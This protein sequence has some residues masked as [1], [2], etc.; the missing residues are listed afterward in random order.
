M[1]IKRSLDDR[2]GLVII[3]QDDEQSN[4]IK[5]YM[6]SYGYDVFIIDVLS[7][8]P[9]LL[10]LDKIK[11]DVIFLSLINFGDDKGKVLQTI[12]EK[13]PIIPI[14]VQTKHDELKLLI[15]S[16]QDSIT[17]CFFNPVSKEHLFYSIR[18]IL[19]R[20]KNSSAEEQKYFTLDSL[21]AVS[22]EMIQVINLARKS[23]YCTI[24]VMIE[25]EFGVGKKTLAHSIHASGSRA[26]FPFVVVNCGISDQDKIEKDLFGKVDL[27]GENSTCFL[28]KFVEANGGTILLED[29]SALSLKVQS[30]ILNFIETGKIEFDDSRNALKLDVRLIF[31]TEKN[32]FQEVNNQV[33]SKDLYYKI[34]VFSCKIPTLRSRQDDIPWLARFFLKRFC[35]ENNVQQINLSEKALSMLTHYKWTDN[36][37]ELENIILRSVVGIKDSYITEDCFTSLLFESGNQEKEINSNTSE[38]F[39]I[40][41]IQD[42]NNNIPQSSNYLSISKGTIFSIDKYGEIR[43]LSDIEKEMIRLAMKLYREQMSEVARRLGIGRSTLYRKIKEYNI[44]VDSL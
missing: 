12:V 41:C 13:M 31:A 19:E 16:V 5:E 42:E 38:T 29:P 20:K 9:D 30:K 32:L 4:L 11:V 10:V 34:S 39:D 6:E 21:I 33:F 24:P 15:S 23:V 1:H 44:E 37:Q 8:C 40:S 27:Q 43:R 17:K 22:P 28:G 26:S 36:V 25:G 14:I 7:Q 2:Q 35:L 18:S 3:D